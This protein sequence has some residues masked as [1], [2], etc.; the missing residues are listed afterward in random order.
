MA[1]ILGII[2]LSTTARETL[3]QSAFEPSSV[4][5]YVETCNHF[6]MGW[7]G[8]LKVMVHTPEVSVHLDGWLQY[9]GQL[10]LEAH[11]LYRLLED[12]L[13]QRLNPIHLHGDFV[14]SFY[15]KMLE[16][17]I[18][19]RDKM[20]V[21][22]LYYTQTS[23]L[24]AFA[25]RPQILLTLPGVS[26]A[27][28]PFYVAR[29]AALHYRYFDNAEQ[30]SPYQQICQLPAATQLLFQGKE[31][32]LK[33]YWNLQEQSDFSGSEE[34]LS[35][36]YKALLLQAVSLR[37]QVASRPA[38][39]LSG[40]MDSSSVLACAVH[41]SGDKLPAFSTVYEDSTYDESED[42]QTILD[43]HVSQWYALEI[44]N[45]LDFKV[46]QEM[47][48][49]HDEP[50]A[51]AT[52]LSHYLLCQEVARQGFDSLWGGLGG[53]ELNA[54]EYEHFLY[55]FADLRASGQEELLES[56]ISD[57]IHHHNHPIFKKSKQE[58][59]R[60]FQA[61]IDFDT[62]G[63]CFPEPDRLTRYQSVLNPAYFELVDFKPLTAHPFR[64]YLKNRTYQ[65]ISSETLP[66][67]LR[68]EERHASAQRI[69]HFLPFLDDRLV[70]FMFR[71]PGHLKIKNGVSKYLLRQAT[72]GLL[73]HET[74]TRVKKTG[75]NAPAHLW[76][77]G[78]GKE[79]VL[80]LVHSQAFKKRGIYNQSQVIQLIEEHD[81]IVQSQQLKEN[82]MM[83]IWQLVNL[84]LWL[85]ELEKL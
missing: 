35:E 64:S 12:Y 84:E 68:A 80:D 56:E 30:D 39:T 2:G 41:L 11:G 40:G 18:I 52:W 83:F 48:R 63:Y 53:D 54:G 5:V 37:L 47:I 19:Y 73:P 49:T 58:V 46:I 15:D 74:R 59:E 26:K 79:Q 62:A 20:G 13:N 31:V 22:P 77:S 76:F 36:Q 21:K 81:E 72:R 65:D 51:T 34:E 32:R 23:N 57:W 33:R 42:I 69:S 44:G 27:V 78:K 10:I 29:Y 45:Q 25:S 17:L 61:C 28:N 1:R 3:I 24:F 14:L 16:R 60:G 85:L 43:S 7:C 8:P 9:R 67:C 50:I 4:R 6:T 82:H 55:Y 71:V 75:W 38:F 70:E 66:C